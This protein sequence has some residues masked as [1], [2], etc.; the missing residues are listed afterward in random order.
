MTL[1]KAIPLA[2][3]LLAAGAACSSSASRTPTGPAAPACAGASA[4]GPGDAANPGSDGG[5]ADGPGAGFVWTVAAPDPIARFEANGAVVD[6]ELWVLGGFTSADLQVTVSVDVYDPA[7][8][9]WRAGPDLPG[10]ETHIA[11]VTL[12]S[13]VIVAGG[14]T[15]AFTAA[16]PPTT[17]AVWRW[18]AG[19]GTWSPGPPLPAPGAA[20]A[21][22]LLGTEL[23]VAG[24]LAADG[25]SDSDAHEAWDLAG[26]ATWTTA[27]PL[28]DGRNHGGGAATGGLFYALA[29]RHGWDETSGDVADV[30][31]FDPVSGAWSSRA[32]IPTARSEI[33]GATSTTADGRIVVVGG[34]IAG[35]VPSADVLVYDPGADAWCALPSLPEPRKGAVAARIGS[36]IVVA[37]GS[38]TSVD[39]SATT[40]VGCCL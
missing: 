12:A 36:R 10:A 23:H 25:S 9:A 34:S 38:P 31:A 13:D 18:S 29:G 4:A 26:A 20:F 17:D 21:W 30:D 19:A 7:G 5:E 39:P 16:R 32:P 2:T 40:F 3:A 37:G 22:A 14:F 8:D 27:A 24:G 33:G 1:A 35:A 28:P 11:V 15:G 6:G